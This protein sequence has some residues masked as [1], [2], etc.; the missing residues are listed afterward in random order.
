MEGEAAGSGRKRGTGFREEA[1]LH[2]G[3]K[4]GE[5]HRAVKRG[6]GRPQQRSSSNSTGGR[7]ASGVNRG[8]VEKF[9]VSGLESVLGQE[10]KGSHGLAKEV[11]KGSRD[12]SRSDFA[13]S[14]AQCH[15]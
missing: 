1:A 15:P 13:H 2:L 3:L 7:R 6:K 14:A 11:D 8:H 9:G 4:R 5:A 10:R 12:T